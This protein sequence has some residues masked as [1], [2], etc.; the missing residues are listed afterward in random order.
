MYFQMLF[1]PIALLAITAFAVACASTG[2]NRNPLLIQH[3]QLLSGAA[4]ST[5]GQPLPPVQP[6]DL[7]AVSDEMRTFLDKH[8]AGRN[9]D[10]R[11]T[12][13]IIKYLLDDGLELQ[14]SN[15]KT[16]TAAQTFQEREGNCLSFTNLFV[17]MAREVG[18]AAYFQEVRIP[19]IWTAEGDTFYYN[20][21]INA[22]VKS[23]KLEQVVDFDIQEFD[24]GLSRR[25]ISDDT[26]A[27]QYYNN[28]GAYYLTKKD[29]LRAF[30]HAR[31]AIELRPNTGYFWTNLG[32]IL[33]HA[34]KLLHAEQAYLVAIELSQE[35]SAMSNLARLYNTLGK[36]ELASEY[37]ARVKAFRRK[38]PYFLYVR[39]EQ[40]YA[41]K[42]YESTQKLLRAAIRRHPDEHQFYRLQGLTWLKLNQPKK[43]KKSFARAAK[44]A[45]Q[46]E[47]ATVY[48]RKLKLLAQTNQ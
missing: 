24:T 11:K 6:V 16:Y 31:K 40:A 14:Y 29:L 28:M 20:L 23:H 4:I 43:A 3:A 27:A 38:N 12:E 18:V 48:E 30:V 42:N 7:L 17:A 19:P 39:A 46:S 15:L 8:I 22:L 9:G 10:A 2:T 44:V 21:H 26:A 45:T 47:H 13:L 32:T 1:R 25:R 36:P 5:D 33:R 35:L 34:D 37:Q 41:D